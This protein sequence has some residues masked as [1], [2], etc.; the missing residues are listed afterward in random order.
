MAK[1][2]ASPEVMTA[3]APLWSFDL[4]IDHRD[5]AGPSSLSPPHIRSLEAFPSPISSL[6]VIVLQ[7]KVLYF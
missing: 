5:I 1:C 2:R 4:T 6:L 3:A 7:I